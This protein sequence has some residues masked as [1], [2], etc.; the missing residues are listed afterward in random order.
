[1]STF[2]LREFAWVAGPR[3]KSVDGLLRGLM[4]GAPL[5]VLLWTLFFAV[6]LLS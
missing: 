2:A 5:S 6:L 4:F 3:T 1:M